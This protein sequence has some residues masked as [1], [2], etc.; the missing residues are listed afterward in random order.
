MQCVLA[1]ASDGAVEIHMDGLDYPPHLGPEMMLRA[2]FADPNFQAFARDVGIRLAVVEPFW[3]RQLQMLLWA[4]HPAAQAIINE[5]PALL[6]ML[7]D[8]AYSSNWSQQEISQL[9]ACRQKEILSRLGYVGT[10]SAVRLLSRLAINRFDADI[11]GMLNTLLQDETLVTGLRHH[12]AID[13][14]RL[15]VIAQ[16]PDMVRARWLLALQVH[17]EITKPLRDNV[18][19]LSRHVSYIRDLLDVLRDDRSLLLRCRSPREVRRL[20]NRL[21]QRQ[22]ML[23]ESAA[24]QPVDYDDYLRLCDFQLRPRLAHSD[25]VRP[26]PV[27]RLPVPVGFSRLSCL[28]DL[29]DLG[30]AQENCIGSYYPSIKQGK[31]VV[32]RAELAAEVA[33]VCLIIAGGRYDQVEFSGFE[34][35]DVSDAMARMIRAWW[36]Q[37]A[38]TEALLD[39]DPAPAGAFGFIQLELPL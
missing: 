13:C 26:L 18:L 36:L 15:M 34:N 39:A 9:L 24:R 3:F 11:W 16:H 14:A 10:G 19:T 25:R 37:I 7:L 6:W 17:T 20:R 23:S 38:G 21:L 32:L 33:T 30:A 27:Y 12:P 1:C 29:V 28:G 2:H 22:A 8:Q 4:A 5:R 31:C 35:G